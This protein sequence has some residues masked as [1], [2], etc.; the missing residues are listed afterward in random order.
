MEAVKEAYQKL[1]KVDVDGT[2][3]TTYYHTA[4]SRDMCSSSSAHSNP[5]ISEREVDHI[6]CDESA[7]IALEELQ[8][9]EVEAQDDMSCLTL[10]FLDCVDS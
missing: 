1:H 6:F 5:N 10:P 2:R 8:K 3:A 4:L 7:C 9:F